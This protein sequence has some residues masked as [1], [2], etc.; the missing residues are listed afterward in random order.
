LR[1]LNELFFTN[2]SSVYRN[3]CL[4]INLPHTAVHK[5]NNHTYRRKVD[6]QYIRPKRWGDAFSYLKL[7]FF[8]TL[9][10]YRNGSVIK[11]RWGGNQSCWKLT[12]VS[13]IWCLY[14]NSNIF[15]ISRGICYYRLRVF[16]KNF[17]Q[18]CKLFPS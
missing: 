15:N 7:S 16:V 12:S 5:V 8:I 2:I 1:E 6:P 14:F 3:D 11:A 10:F 18:P 13:A 9:I 4:S 17:N